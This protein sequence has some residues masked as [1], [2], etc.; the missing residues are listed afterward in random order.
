MRPIEEILRTY[1]I[2]NSRAGSR[3]T[4][5]F[6]A[7]L[8][9]AGAFVVA[10]AMLLTGGPDPATS[11]DSF[12][13]SKDGKEADPPLDKADPFTVGVAET[14]DQVYVGYPTSLYD[15]S[16]KERYD[17]D[18]LNSSVIEWLAGH[19]ETPL[20][21]APE[22]VYDPQGDGILMG[23]ILHKAEAPSLP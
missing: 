18:A 22:A 11:P 14:Q 12:S 2:V 15:P 21:G 1:N 7:G 3:Y 17:R 5:R 6:L 8:F 10:G 19:P 20:D 23:Y 13:A 16:Q 9:L 4:V